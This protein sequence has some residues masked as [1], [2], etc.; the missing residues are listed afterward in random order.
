[1]ELSEARDAAAASATTIAEIARERDVLKR[2]LVGY[3]RRKKAGGDFDELI[4]G[5]NVIER[6]GMTPVKAKEEPEPE[7]EEEEEGFF[8]WLTTPS[9]QPD[10]EEKAKKKEEDDEPGFFRTLF[11]LTPSKDAAGEGGARPAASEKSDSSASRSDAFATAAPRFRS[12]AS[13]TSGDRRRDE[14]SREHAAVDPEAR[15]LARV[16]EPRGGARPRGAGRRPVRRR[17]RRRIRRRVG[18]RSARR[19]GG[20][21]V[22]R[23]VEIGSGGVLEARGRR[24]RGLFRLGQRRVRERATVTATRDRR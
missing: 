24:R 22:G 16:A 20:V 12:G 8:A 19:R 11:G 1:M 13:V 5:S 10:V 23:E 9:R 3:E 4:S 6:L 7:E 14:E 17:R 18:R 21:R 2:E 15:P